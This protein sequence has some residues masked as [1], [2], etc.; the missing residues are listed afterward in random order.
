MKTSGTRVLGWIAAALVLLIVVPWTV[1]NAVE[2]ARL[3]ATLKKMAAR[4]WPMTVAEL[5]PPALPDE[6]N[7]A[8]VLNGKTWANLDTTDRKSVV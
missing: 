5:R 7:A 8:L 4:G 2:G 3:R 1:G 6:Q